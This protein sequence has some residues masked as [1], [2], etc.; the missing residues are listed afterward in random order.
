MMSIDFCSGRNN[1][2]RIVLNSNLSSHCFKRFYLYDILQSLKAFAHFVPYFL[3]YF[4][5]VIDLILVEGMLPNRVHLLT[6]PNFKGSQFVFVGVV[7][8]DLL[9]A[10]G[11]IGVV[12]PS[13]T[14]IKFIVDASDA[15]VSGDGQSQCV[16]LT[17]RSVGKS[18][19]PKD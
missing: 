19:R 18:Y 9:Y 15:V 16:I 13:S 2:G 8:I 6:C 4:D 11:G 1:S 5:K 3:L 10:K 14:K 7:G 12:L 17:I